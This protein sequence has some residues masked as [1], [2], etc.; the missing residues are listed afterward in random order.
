MKL[1]THQLGRGGRTAA[2]VHGATKASDDWRDFARILVD[3]YDLSL[4]LVDLRGH[5]DSQRGSSYRVEDFAADL[6]D[7][8]PTGLDFLIGQSLGGV[9]TAWAAPLLRPRRYIGVD[10][11]FTAT[12]GTAV[13]MRMVAPLGSLLTRLPDS[14]LS[15]LA[16]PPKG[17]A[18]D[19][20]QRVLA[21]WRQWDS[22]MSRQLIAS[23]LA[24]PFPL[25]PPAVPSTLAL[26]ERSR[27][28]PP[29]MA[30]Q[31]SALGWD[32]RVK[33]GGGHDLHVED[34]RGLVALL[35]DVLREDAAPQ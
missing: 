2:L 1:A 20:R 15:A 9:S 12:T 13:M 30:G 28:V 27:F 16:V 22:S 8:L 23:G 18:P 5:G 14:V 31:L 35:D 32:I 17:S 25:G 34:P 11:A 7:T 26:A 6:V 21:M 29:Q 24:R 4:I 10:P 3:D 19:T 33:P